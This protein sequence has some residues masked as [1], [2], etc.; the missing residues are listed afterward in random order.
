MP[1]IMSLSAKGIF[2][3]VW[4]KN[5]KSQDRKLGSGLKSLLLFTMTVCQKALVS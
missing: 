4:Q 1:E 5:T 3:V 2:I